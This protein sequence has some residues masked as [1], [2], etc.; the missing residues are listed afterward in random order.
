M[1]AHHLAHSVRFHAKTPIQ[2]WDGEQFV[3]HSTLVNL[4]AGAHSA[5]AKATNTMGALGNDPLSGVNT[6]KDPAGQVYNI[7]EDQANTYEGTTY[8]TTY[9]IRRAPFLAEII[10][11]PVKDVKSGSGFAYKTTEGA[12]YKDWAL[13]EHDRYFNAPA[14]VVRQGVNQIFLGYLP[15]KLK[16]AKGFV[17][18]LDNGFSYEVVT[19]EQSTSR[20]TKC[21]MMLLEANHERA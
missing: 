6:F 10:S 8:G 12:K 4:K 20:S 9:Y 7:L 16:P 18:H 21:F 15:S 5:D 13:L 14:P 19:A 17:V 1:Y 3:K 11:N 2:V